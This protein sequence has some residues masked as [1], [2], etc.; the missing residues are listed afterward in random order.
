MTQVNEPLF[1]QVVQYIE[2][3]PEQ[4]NQ[5]KFGRLTAC[6]TQH[7]LAGWA[8]EFSD[9][10]FQWYTDSLG[11]G[12]PKRGDSFLKGRKAL[13]LTNDQAEE[14]FYDT[15]TDSVDELKDAITRVT[16]LEFKKERN[17]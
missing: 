13:G 12:Y 14:L 10:D 16:G 5:R 6:G 11:N 7:C 3:N 2:D 15:Q 8:I 17:G 1:R 4:W 9:G